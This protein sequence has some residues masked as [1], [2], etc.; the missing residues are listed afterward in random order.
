MSLDQVLKNSSQSSE[1]P[2]P[3]LQYASPRTEKPSRSIYRAVIVL[4]FAP[5][6]LGALAL[7]ICWL[8][9]RGWWRDY[10]TLMFAISGGLVLAA[11][12]ALA[13]F[14]FRERRYRRLSG[15]ELGL[16]MAL[17]CLLLAANVPVMMLYAA[18]PQRLTRRETVT[19]INTGPATIDRFVVENSGVKTDIGP[20]AP[21]AAVTGSF[22]VP[23]NSWLSFEAWQT[24]GSSRSMSG[25]SLG[26]GD[27]TVTM[28][29]AGM[30]IK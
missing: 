19:V 12:A 21:G 3:A 13:V 14:L 30:T 24:R 2:V 11:S 29:T 7:L 15:G 28:T 18:A 16:R 4:G 22:D 20:I 8:M 27:R 26:R 25:G 23:M 9:R 1:R 10:T 6:V 17:A 5:M